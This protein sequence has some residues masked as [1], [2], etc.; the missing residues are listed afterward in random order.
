MAMTKERLIQL[1]ADCVN[2]TDRV[3]CL[4]IDLAPPCCAMFNLAHALDDSL[5]EPFSTAF[6]TFTDTTLM[7]LTIVGPDQ[8]PIVR[9][10]QGR[11]LG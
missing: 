9:V 1:V 6:A 3:E 5:G 8:A 7:S 10:L 4:A 11:R 2:P